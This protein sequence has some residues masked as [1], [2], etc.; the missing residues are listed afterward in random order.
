MGR[1]IV[2]GLNG[3]LKKTLRG[4][5]ALGTGQELLQRIGGKPSQDAE[6]FL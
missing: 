1:H 5:V 4:P 6:V 3:K 2:D